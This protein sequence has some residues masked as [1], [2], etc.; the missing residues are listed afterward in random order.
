LLLTDVQP[1]E[2]I[3][4]IPEPHPPLPKPIPGPIVLDFSIGVS[5]SSITVPVGGSGTLKVTLVDQSIPT[6]YSMPVNVSLFSNLDPEFGGTVFIS[7]GS[8][9]F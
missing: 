9:L 1:R 6:A 2:S 8:N 4:P 7:S 3:K 5:P